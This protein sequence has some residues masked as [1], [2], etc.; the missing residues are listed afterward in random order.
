MVMAPITEVSF[1]VLCMKKN[2]V[3]QVFKFRFLKNPEQF[4]LI[5]IL[6][7]LKLWKVF[8]KI[9]SIHAKHLMEHLKL[10]RKI[11]SLQW[12]SEKLSRIWQPMWTYLCKSLKILKIFD[13]LYRSWQ[14]ILKTAKILE[15]DKDFDQDLSGYSKIFESLVP[16]L[17]SQLQ[18]L[19]GSETWD[20]KSGQKDWNSQCKTRF[21]RRPEIKLKKG[22]I[23]P[24]D[25][26]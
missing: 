16:I 20:Q 4:L 1:D 12:I 18:R 25:F 3:H 7:K 10:S 14:R 19:K 26:L 23:L 6:K 24:D 9:V 5:L 13:N 17:G 22:K 15:E 11:Q 8:E 2:T 21:H